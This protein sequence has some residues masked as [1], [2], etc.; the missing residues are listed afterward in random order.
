MESLPTS[1]ATALVA[2]ATPAPAA[3][4]PAAPASTA[5]RRTT[6][7][8]LSHDFRLAN[9]RLA[10]RLRQEKPDS[11]LSS[12]QFSALG[13]LYFHGPFTLRELSEHER[14]TPPSMNRTVNA[15]VEEGLVDRAGSVDDGRKVVLTVTEQGRTLMRDTR[16]RR[17]AWLAQRVGKLTPEQ[18]RVLGE[19]MEIMKELTNS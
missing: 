7:A 13:S 18:R 19:A 11:E 6:V 15:L 2:P 12:S 14:V 5:V 3:P 9:G 1:T 16:K 4:A 10:R 17:D 8:E